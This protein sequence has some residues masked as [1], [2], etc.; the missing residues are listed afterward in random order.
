MR[1]RVGS[2]LSGKLQPRC[3]EPGAQQQEVKAGPG[4]PARLVGGMSPLW[5]GVENAKLRLVVTG[6]EHSHSVF[7]T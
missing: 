5:K 7:L 6:L 2:A 3:P 4:R 1:T